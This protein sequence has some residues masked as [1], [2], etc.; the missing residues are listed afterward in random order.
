[1]ASDRVSEAL[2]DLI[3]GGERAFAAAGRGAYMTEDSLATLEEVADELERHEEEIT[4]RKKTAEDLRE[5]LSHVM[6]HTCDGGC[7]EV[8]DRYDAIVKVQ[9][10]RDEAAAAFTTAA[11]SRDF[12]METI[13]AVIEKIETTEVS[14]PSLYGILSRARVAVVLGKTVAEK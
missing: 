9:L 11:Q 10:D 4:Q 6:G 14:V 5:Q 12:L 3:S 2:R 13:E 7:I 8:C 1:M